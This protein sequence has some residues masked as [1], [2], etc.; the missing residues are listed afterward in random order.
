[1]CFSCI[2]QDLPVMRARTCVF[3]W[4]CVYESVCECVCGKECRDSENEG[5]WVCVSKVNISYVYF[6]HFHLGQLVW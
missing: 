5:M 6:R 2:H 4:L 3:V 1:M